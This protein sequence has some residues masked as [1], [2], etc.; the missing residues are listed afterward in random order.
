MPRFLAAGIRGWE[1]FYKCEIFGNLELAYY[2]W[3][4]WWLGCLVK[5]NP[6]IKEFYDDAKAR[7]AGWLFRRLLKI[8]VELTIK[9]ESDEQIKKAVSNGNWQNFFTM[10]I[11]GVGLGTWLLGLL[12]FYGTKSWVGLFGLFIG[13]SIKIACFVLLANTLGLWFY[14]I[15]SLIAIIK[16]YKFILPKFRTKLV[17]LANN[18]A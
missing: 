18:H 8:F 2:T 12:I 1:L 10:F 15:V 6:K 7:G 14:A 3:F 17:K 13:N 5:E 11:Q 4:F 9:K 16:A